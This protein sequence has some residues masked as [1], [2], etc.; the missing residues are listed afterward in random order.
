[1]LHTNRPNTVVSLMILFL[2]VLL[3]IIH[4]V[5]IADHVDTFFSN[6]VNMLVQYEKL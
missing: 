4:W 6:F 5:V 3:I 1:M 2:C